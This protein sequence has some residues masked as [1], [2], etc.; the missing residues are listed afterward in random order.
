MSG[1]SRDLW[2]ASQQHG[3]CPRKLG[4]DPPLTGSTCGPPEQLPQAT[5]VCDNVNRRPVELLSDSLVSQVL[6]S[7]DK[8]EEGKV[9][10]AVSI[11][12]DEILPAIEGDRHRHL[13]ICPYPRASYS[14][15][16]GSL[17]PNRGKVDDGVH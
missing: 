6:Y 11:L 8:R 16:S 1:S 13:P 7:P 12:V 4:I 15:G 14:A 9:F 3:I 2:A 5:S 17:D 10:H